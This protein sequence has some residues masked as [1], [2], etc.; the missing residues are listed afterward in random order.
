MK[1]QTETVDHQNSFESPSIK[2]SPTVDLEVLIWSALT[3]K[4]GRPF[5]I[6]AILPK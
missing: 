1:F 2:L 3:N 4:C 5:Q 6:L